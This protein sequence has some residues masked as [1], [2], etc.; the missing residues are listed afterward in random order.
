VKEEVSSEI[1]AEIKRP[2][3]HVSFFDT[4]Y[5]KTIQVLTSVGK[6]F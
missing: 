3:H 2:Q 6:R 1:K 5:R 4:Q